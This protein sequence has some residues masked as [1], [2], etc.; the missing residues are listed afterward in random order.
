MCRRTYLSP[1]DQEKTG[2]AIVHRILNQWLQK[3][4]VSPR[5]MNPL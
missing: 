3:V 2:Y 1:S 5:D 4:E